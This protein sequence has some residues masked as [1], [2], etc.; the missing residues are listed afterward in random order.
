M[1]RFIQSVGEIATALIALGTVGSAIWLIGFKRPWK[2]IRAE[3]LRFSQAV[4]KV[5]SINAA[6]GP[7]GGSSLWD[8]ARRTY[9]QARL[10]DARVDLLVDHVDYPIFESSPDGS[11]VRVNDAFVRTLGYSVSDMFGHKWIRL[12]SDGDRDRYVRAWE[13]AV[14]DQRVFETEALLVTRNSTTLRVR[15]RATPNFD[16]GSGELLRWLGRIETLE[17]VKAGGSA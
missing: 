2:T 12:L 10:T 6:L 13:L 9:N 17:L 1:I 4:T 3:Y 5:D 14:K 8:L 16:E 7:N 11:T 15:V